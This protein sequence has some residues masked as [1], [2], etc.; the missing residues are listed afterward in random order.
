MIVIKIRGSNLSATKRDKPGYRVWDNP[1]F[2]RQFGGGSSGASPERYIR[3]D[4]Y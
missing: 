2:Q 3:P 4:L 1:N